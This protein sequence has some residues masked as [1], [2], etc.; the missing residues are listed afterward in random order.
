MQF[1]PIPLQQVQRKQLSSDAV[2]NLV[3]EAATFNSR[4]SRDRARR[5]HFSGIHPAVSQSSSTRDMH[6]ILFGVIQLHV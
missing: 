5:V 3:K 2:H 6:C 4:V 1:L